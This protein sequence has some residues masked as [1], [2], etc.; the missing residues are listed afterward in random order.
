M[1]FALSA[2]IFDT[3]VHENMC[4]ACDSRSGASEK[5]KIAGA[6]LSILWW[7]KSNRFWCHQP[8]YNRIYRIMTKLCRNERPRLV[9]IA[10]T[11]AM[12]ND[13]NPRMKSTIVRLEN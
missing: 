5:R 9:E 1:N 6:S 2:D 7:S 8:E 4:V 12:E 3:V 13:S 11:N 10:T